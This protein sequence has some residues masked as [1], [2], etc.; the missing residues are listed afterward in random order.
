MRKTELTRREQ[1]IMI[2]D[3]TAAATSRTA[4]ESGTEV[5]PRNASH[6]MTTQ[7]QDVWP[8]AGTKLPHAQLTRTE[9]ILKQ[10]AIMSSQK[11]M[12]P[13]A[14]RETLPVGHSLVLSLERG[15]APTIW[16][17]PG[18]QL[19]HAHL[20]WAEW[21]DLLANGTI[22]EQPAQVTSKRAA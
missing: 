17:L 9:W 2:I 6:D 19:P 7:P 13:A 4:Q 18:T 5:L 8:L 22:T 1:T 20:S 3:S 14:S 15:T 10:A 12:M 16:P 21:V 11:Y